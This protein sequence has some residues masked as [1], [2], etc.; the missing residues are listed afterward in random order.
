MPITSITSAIASPEAQSTRI[1]EEK[2]IAP[3]NLGSSPPEAA[4]GGSAEG[5]GFM[6]LVKGFVGDVNHLQI[7]G[8]QAVDALAAGEIADVHQVTVAVAEA[9]LALDLLLQVRNR[10]TEAFQEVMRMQV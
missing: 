10:V 2:G 9:G 7:R 6:D 5:P 8:G 4:P 1:F 3:R